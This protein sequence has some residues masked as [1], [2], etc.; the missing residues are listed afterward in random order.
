MRA[1]KPPPANK[2]SMRE[3]NRSLAL[4]RVLR[5]KLVSL[6]RAGPA[7]GVAIGVILHRTPH[8]AAHHDPLGSKRL[9][10]LKRIGIIKRPGARRRAARSSLRARAW[11]PDSA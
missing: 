1:W 2:D 4:L 5:R 7:G 8:A 11:R 6:M 3:S 9:G 10:I